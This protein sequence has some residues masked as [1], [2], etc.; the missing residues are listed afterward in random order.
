VGRDAA[1]AITR[2]ASATCPAQVSARIRHFVGRG[3]VDITGLGTNWV[4]RFL[5]EG[6]VSTAADL[7]HLTREQ[8]L[9]LEGSGMGEVL[10]DKLLGSI[11]ASRRR[12]PLA[13]FLFGLGIRHV[14]LETADLIAPLIGSLDALRAGLRESEHEHGQEHGQEGG[15]SDGGPYVVRLHAEILETKGLGAAVADSVA[16]A[17]RNPTTLGLLDRFAAGGLSPIPVAPRPRD[18]AAPT[19]PLAGKT[20]VLTGALGEPREA[21]AA[22]IE[23]AGGKVTD[24]VSGATT[25]VVAGDRPGGSKIKGAAKH[26]VPVVDESALRALLPADAPA[27]APADQAQA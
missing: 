27:A 3:A 7:Y 11:D 19:G 24:A 20:F 1:E 23:A 21:V 15:A 16:G 2:C 18:G 8:L 26:G 17:L 6:F 14:G 5:A 4:D 9:S 22:L 13:R 10:A 25:Y 12:T